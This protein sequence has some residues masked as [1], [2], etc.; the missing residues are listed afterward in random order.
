LGSAPASWL[1]YPLEVGIVPVFYAIV[2]LIAN[3][4]RRII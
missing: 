4:S 2:A 3:E 1:R